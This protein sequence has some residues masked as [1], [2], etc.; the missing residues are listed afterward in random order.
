MGK[1][2]KLQI[3]LQYGTVQEIWALAI[4]T[5]EGKSNNLLQNTVNTL[6]QTPSDKPT[7]GAPFRNDICP[8]TQTFH[9]G[10]LTPFVQA[11]CNVVRPILEIVPQS[12]VNENP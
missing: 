3:W 10:S 6:N 1:Q 9:F 11:A 4:G 12:N 2:G 7:L 5:A 8:Q